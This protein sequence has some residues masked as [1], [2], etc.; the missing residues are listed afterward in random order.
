MNPDAVE[1]MIDNKGKPFSGR[2][3]SRLLCF[4]YPVQQKRMRRNHPVQGNKRQPSA[5]RP[6]AACLFPR[7]TNCCRWRFLHTNPQKRPGHCSSGQK[8][9]T[10]TSLSKET[11][12]LYTSK[13]RADKQYARRYGGADDEKSCRTRDMHSKM[14]LTS[15]PLDSF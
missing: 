7:L 11:V 8:G 10:R 6:I 9:R 2:R 5:G 4:H 14:R 1:H 3:G 13:E 12:E 15:P